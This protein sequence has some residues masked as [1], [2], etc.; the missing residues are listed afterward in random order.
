M[1]DM[2]CPPAGVN[3]IPS[4][5]QPHK[6]MERSTIFIIFHGKIH[7]FLWPCSIAF[8]M[9]TR[10]YLSN[11]STMLHHFSVEQRSIFLY[12]LQGPEPSWVS[13]KNSPLAF[14]Q[15]L[16]VQNKSSYMFLLLLMVLFIMIFHM[17]M[18]QYQ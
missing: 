4:G 11:S 17:A 12:S 13:E 1:A 16:A 7:Y 9:F 2:M 8:C 6:T 15:S 5:K 14:C 10:G 3:S 18:C